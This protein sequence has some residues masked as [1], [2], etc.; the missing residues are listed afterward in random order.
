MHTQAIHPLKAHTPS[1]PRPL[2]APVTLPASAPDDRPMGFTRREL[3][4][5]VAEM[6]G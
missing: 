5:L 3:R 6:I 1:H 4:R 2:A